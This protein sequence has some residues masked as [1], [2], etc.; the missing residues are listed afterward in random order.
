MARF[1]E[2]FVHP[3]VEWELS[4]YGNDCCDS[5]SYTRADTSDGYTI[6]FPNTDK[7]EDDEQT[8]MFQFIDR[9]EDK[10]VEFDCVSKLANYVNY[11][12]NEIKIVAPQD[13]DT[14]RVEGGYEKFNNGTHICLDIPDGS[15]TISCKL[16]DGTV[17]TFA[18]C[19]YDS[20]MSGKPQV[21]ACV[22]VQI[23]TGAVDQFERQSKG[24][25][26]HFEGQGGIIFAG[27]NRKD[28]GSRP[29]ELRFEPSQGYALSTF[30][31]KRHYT[32][33]TSG[34]SQAFFADRPDEVSSFRK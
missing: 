26:D 28:K 22:D 29:P 10:W 18:F 34:I 14:D 27:Q 31:L 6:Y 13:T 16:S 9:D 19:P 11:Y 30:F 20:A 33:H 3:T 32:E 17:A 4:N 7:V 12:F 2:L 5:L 25:G 21:P 23:K 15:S 1:L 8:V 24:S